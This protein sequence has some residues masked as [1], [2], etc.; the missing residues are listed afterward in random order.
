[1]P[2]W[3]YD[4]LCYNPSF[5]HHAT[6]WEAA[7]QHSTVSGATQHGTAGTGG[8]EPGGEPPLRLHAGPREEV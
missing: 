8:G 7:T 3:G 6:T 2:T 5:A 1:M 4:G